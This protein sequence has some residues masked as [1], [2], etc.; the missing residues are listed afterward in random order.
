MRITSNHW[1]SITNSSPFTLNIQEQDEFDSSSTPFE[2][3]E[4]LGIAACKIATL[5]KKVSRT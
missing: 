2:I 1:R 5:R 3:T 4:E